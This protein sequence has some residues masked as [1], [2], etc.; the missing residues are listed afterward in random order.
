MPTPVVPTQTKPCSNPKC[1]R[2]GQELPLIAFYRNRKTADGRIAWCKECSADR[3]RLQRTVSPDSG[4][5]RK[6][7]KARLERV[8]KPRRVKLLCVC[9]LCPDG[10]DEHMAKPVDGWSADIVKKAKSGYKPRRYCA[11]HGG[12]MWSFHTDEDRGA[13]Y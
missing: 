3:Q 11:E 10:K 13:I 5:Q 9:S 8:K 2:A 12:Q 4:T 6:N 7:E 1:R